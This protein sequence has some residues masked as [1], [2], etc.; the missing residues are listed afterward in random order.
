MNDE[1]KRPLSAGSGD[2]GGEG[3]EGRDSASEP[4]PGLDV[5][6]R[7]GAVVFV[8]GT[9]L[10]GESNHHLL[11]G[12]HFLGEDATAPGFELRDFGAFPAM[13]AA[14][15]GTVAGEVY[16]VDDATLTVLDRLEDH[17]SFY[18]RTPIT[19]ASGADA[20]AY[21]LEARQAHGRARIPSGTWRDR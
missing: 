3:P 5:E 19:L 2:P 20:E 8:Y 10:R 13:L 16:V 9:L 12:A 6:I 7:S 17:P 1:R 11:A 18:R 4:D 15:T 21:L 14:G